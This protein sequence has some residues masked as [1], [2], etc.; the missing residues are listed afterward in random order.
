MSLQSHAHVGAAVATRRVQLGLRQSDLAVAAGVSE[1]T[2]RNIEAGRI[3]GRPTKWPLVER[4]LG[5]A[6]GS[7]EVLEAGEQPRQLD[8][9]PS[10]PPS[11]E[12]A[13]RLPKRVRDELAEHELFDSAVLDIAGGLRV[14]VLAL[15][16]DPP[17]PERHGRRRRVERWEG[18]QRQIHAAA[19]ESGDPS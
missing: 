1:T 3:G 13:A 8:A 14:I 12:W 10:E 5:W 6:P 4:A 18:V 11:G 16:T 15:E 17:P 2:V 19:T 7:F 9:S